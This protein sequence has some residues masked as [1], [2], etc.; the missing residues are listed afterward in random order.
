MWMRG[1]S[2]SRCNEL[3][4]HRET[5]DQ[6]SSTSRR[7]AAIEISCGLLLALMLS[8][9]GGGG[10]DSPSSAS[11]AAP[12]AGAGSGSNAA[13]TIQ[14]QPG[15]TVLV[16]KSYSFQPIASDSNGDALTFS[17]TN[18][19]SW[20]SFNASTGRISGTPTAA[21][22]ATVSGITITVSDGTAAATLG[23]FNISVAQSASGSAMLSWLPPSLNMDGSSLVDLVG[24]RILY[25]NS[26]ANLT[27]SI[28]ISNPTLSSYLVE[29]LSSGTWYFAIVA[30]NS[31]GVVSDPSGMVSKT[32]T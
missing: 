31:N 32:I 8:A 9:C 4:T 17:A 2:Q 22:L 14:G 30:V 16:G 26:T 5:V 27:Q 7:R 13:P 15:A 21:D 6:I 28:P 10:D 12:P 23:P 25:G 1:A 24:Y 11:A 29:N 3:R 18:L 20:A 19:P